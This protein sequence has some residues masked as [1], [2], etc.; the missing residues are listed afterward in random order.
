MSTY[1]TLRHLAVKPLMC[2]THRRT[3]TFLEGVPAF[4][5]VFFFFSCFRCHV[6]G[7]LG[8]INSHLY[9]QHRS[10]STVWFQSVREKKKSSWGWGGVGGDLL[11]LGS[12][13]F[14]IFCLGTLWMWYNR[15]S[16]S[17]CAV[18]YRLPGLSFL[19]RD[20][21]VVP[22]LPA[23][24]A[25]LT[26]GRTRHP[27]SRFSGWQTDDTCPMPLYS[28]PVFEVTASWTSG[29][30]PGQR[31]W[32][33]RRSCWG[34]QQHWATLQT[35]PAGLADELSMVWERRRRRFG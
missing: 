26:T 19:I 16:I 29:V 30:K 34:E 33:S 2:C 32:S 35:W 21:V 17:V 8:V 22:E 7:T 9:F 15:L 28:L 11:R 6:N 14:F 31:D 4:F 27:S 5:L 18:F 10:N 3:N 1:N 20:V 23:E 24:S 12:L 13:A 25:K